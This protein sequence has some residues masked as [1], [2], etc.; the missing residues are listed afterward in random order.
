MSR[1]LVASSLALVCASVLVSAQARVKEYGRA[2]VQY[3]GPE[4]KA[5]AS[6][7][8]SQ[9]HHDSAWLL[10]EFAVVAKE[11]IAVHRNEFTLLTPDERRV[12]L[13][14][15]Q[16]FLDDHQVLTPL[17][18]NAL[19]WRRPLD[20]YF[21]T[22]PQLTIRFFSKPGGL[23]QDTAVTNQDEVAAGD[24]FFKSPDGAWK[25]GTYRLVLNHQQAKAELPIVLK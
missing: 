18:Q 15:Q 13:A 1:R 7:G 5:V 14:T 9:E 10:I 12:P 22:R 17:L 16:Q 20:S 11:R 4:V 25:A 24:L 19:I 3:S 21:T 2:I 8:Y 23:V 6:Y